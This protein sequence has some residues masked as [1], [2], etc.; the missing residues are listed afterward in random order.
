MIQNL[1]A[2]TLPRKLPTA[3]S[4]PGHSQPDIIIKRC[5][6]SFTGTVDRRVRKPLMFLPGSS[7]E[8]SRVI[9]TK[10]YSYRSAMMGST[11]MARRA[12]M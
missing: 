10:H 3:A 12:G 6:R 11:R 5:C 7:E 2:S 9:W 8:E 1:T 4:P